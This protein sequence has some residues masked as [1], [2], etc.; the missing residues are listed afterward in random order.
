MNQNDA[1]ARN[2]KTELESNNVIAFVPGGNSMWPTLKHRGQSVIVESKKQRLNRFDVA[3]YQ[4]ENGAFVLHRVMEVKEGGYLFCGDSQFNY[5]W[6][7]EE[8][9]FGKMLG[10]YRKDKYVEVTDAK[11]IS[12]VERWF[13]RKKWRRLRLKLFYFNIRLK[14]KLKKT[15][16]KKDGE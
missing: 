3:L 5:E 8:Q 9:T 14:A 10:F 16:S 2:Y 4:R 15:F 1:L 6:V 13:K 12:E 7:L 11:Y